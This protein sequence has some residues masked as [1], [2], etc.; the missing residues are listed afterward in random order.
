MR[1]SDWSSDVC[2][3]D[4]FDRRTLTDTEDLDAKICWCRDC[5]GELSLGPRAAAEL[6]CIEHERRSRVQVRGVHFAHSL[7]NTSGHGY[8]PSCPLSQTSS[9]TSALFP[10]AGSASASNPLRPH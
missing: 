2:S 1:I 4:L 8:L 6:A 3:S 7:H 10:F 9:A 5:S